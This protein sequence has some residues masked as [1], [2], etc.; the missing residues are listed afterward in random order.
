MAAL[1]CGKQTLVMSPSTNVV[2]KP[3][4]YC[5]GCFC[6]LDGLLECRCPQCGRRF[7]PDDPQ[8]FG[9]QPRARKTRLPGA[10]VALLPLLPGVGVFVLWKHTFMAYHP[11]FGI[12]ILV[13]V[14]LLVVAVTRLLTQGRWRAAVGTAA[15]FVA[16]TLPGAGV[17]YWSTTGSQST[18]ALGGQVLIFLLGGPIGVVG[19]IIGAWVGWSMTRFAD[20]GE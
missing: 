8:T 13:G 19:A 1:R 10:A 20:N 15:G 5:L 12:P 2:P 7:D 6:I 3:T 14:V 17:M 18:P 4:M 11:C 16:G 9:T